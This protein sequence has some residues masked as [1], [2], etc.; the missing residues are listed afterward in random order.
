MTPEQLK[1]QMYFRLTVFLLITIVIGFIVQDINTKFELG[2]TDQ[3][4]TDMRR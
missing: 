4:V 1:R 3:T 2:N